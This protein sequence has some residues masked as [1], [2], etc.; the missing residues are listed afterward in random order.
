MCTFAF[1]FVLDGFFSNYVAALQSGHTAFS[2][3]L[4]DFSVGVGAFFIGLSRSPPFSLPIAV[5]VT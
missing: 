4:L 2:G 5:R 3:F 1:M